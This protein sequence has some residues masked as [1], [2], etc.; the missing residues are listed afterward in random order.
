MTDLIKTALSALP[1]LIP[2]RKIKYQRGVEWAEV[3]AT[4]ARSVV[5]YFD[6]AGVRVR[7]EVRDYLIKPSL[8]VLA[9][10]TVEPKEGDVITDSGEG[11]KVTY[12]LLPD[13]A[14]EAW[15]YTDRYHT[16]LRVHVKEIDEEDE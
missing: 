14:G 16:L 1:S 8:L 10:V 4:V 3:D 12:K 11:T 7:S 2:R 6:N 15:R 13:A 9:G 5:E